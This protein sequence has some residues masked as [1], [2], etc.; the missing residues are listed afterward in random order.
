MV[1]AATT[2]SDLGIDTALV[3]GATGDV[4]SWV[5]DRLVDAGVE[6][7]GIDREP[8]TGTR[9][10]L[11][12]RAVDL[13]D[14]GETWET[15]YETNPDA[16]VH[17]AAVSNPLDN[18]GTRVFENNTRS[19]YNTLVAA[20]RG[21]AEVVWLSSQAA[22]GALFATGEWVPDYLPIDEDHP[23]RP[24]DPYGVSKVCSEEVAKMAARRFDVPVTTIRAATI[25]TPD[26]HRTRPPREDVSL[27]SD[28]V[29]GNFGSYVDVRDVA[30]IVAAALAADR[31]GYDDFLCV[32]DENALGP[33]TAEIVESICGT[34]PEQ[35]ALSGKES[36][37]SNAKARRELDWEPVH[38]DA[39]APADEAAP[40]WR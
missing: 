25:H 7:V 10:G 33:P 27:D 31:R 32:A 34:L 19:T 4:G 13:R 22:Y 2:D 29:A 38:S 20:G 30:G 26:D 1:S 16:V 35:C 18:P 39:A 40:A 8:P 3:T 21:G 37:L 36:A 24:E 12:V 28:A 14:A 6:V 23:L 15:V 9:A 17:C 5:C 11:S